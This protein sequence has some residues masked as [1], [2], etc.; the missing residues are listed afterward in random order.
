MRNIEEASE[1]TLESPGHSK[2]H[3]MLVNEVNIDSY[4]IASMDMVGQR[5]F[6]ALNRISESM[7]PAYDT[8]H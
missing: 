3:I 2:L 5:A 6:S 8:N 7:T 1:Q 4:S